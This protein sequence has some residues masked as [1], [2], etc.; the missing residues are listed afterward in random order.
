[1]VQTVSSGKYQQYEFVIDSDH[2]GEFRL[3]SP[4]DTVNV[5]ELCGFEIYPQYRGRRLSHVMLAYAVSEAKRYYFPLVTLKVKQ[6]NA[7]AIRLY[8]NAGFVVK[9]TD[10]DKSELEMEL[11][12]A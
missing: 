1:M 8:T 9:N 7:V 12:I 6:D 4:G 3:L 10:H 11:D 2:V 5:V